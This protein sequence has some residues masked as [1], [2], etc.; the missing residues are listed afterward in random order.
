MRFA[1]SFN[2]VQPLKRPLHR[3]ILM[4][5]DA[6]V[7]QGFRFQGFQSLSRFFGISGESLL[8]PFL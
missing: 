5:T 2:D 4:A 6:M 3:I 8:K 1:P 7:R